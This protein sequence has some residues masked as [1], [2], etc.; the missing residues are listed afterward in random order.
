[1]LLW[2]TSSGQTHA[3]GRLGDKDPPG[4]FLTLFRVAVN[5]TY[6]EQ[7]SG[8]TAA[9]TLESRLGKPGRFRYLISASTVPWVIAAPGSTASPVMVP[10]LCAVTGFSIFIASRTTTKSPAAT[11]WPSSTATFTTVPCI[12][13]VTALPEAAAP[14][15]APRLRGLGFL[16]ITPTASAE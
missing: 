4:T 5:S 10:S 6:F 16:R 1:M 2:I 3:T 13:A 9:T 12:G 8:G 14:A 7:Y 15:C 11:S